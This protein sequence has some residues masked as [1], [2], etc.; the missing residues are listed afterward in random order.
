MRQDDFQS[1][2]V[3]SMEHWLLDSAAF[4]GNASRV[5]ADMSTCNLLPPICQGVCPADI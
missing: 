2:E 4:V 3:R 1:T 5:V